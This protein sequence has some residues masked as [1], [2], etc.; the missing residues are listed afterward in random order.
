MN[1]MEQAKTEY[2]FPV[3]VIDSQNVCWPENLLIRRELQPGFDVALPVRVEGRGFILIDFGRELHGGARIVTYQVRNNHHSAPIRLRFGES[4]SEAC[5]PCG[6]KGASNVH[7]LREIETTLV[8]MSDMRFCQT[9]FRFLRIEFIEDTVLELRSIVAEYRHCGLKFSGSFRSSD[10]LV[11]HIYETAANT[12]YLNFQNGMIWDGIKR[13]RCV[14]VGDMHP[15]SLA[16]RALFGQSDYLERSLDFVVQTTP[17]GKWINDI[18]SYSM[19]WISVIRDYYF[20]TGDNVFLQ[21]FVDFLE[22][23][24]GMLDRSVTESG[25]L[26]FSLS[27]AKGEM[28]FFLDWPTYGTPDGYEGVFALLCRTA[29]AAGT[30]LSECGRPDPTVRRIKEKLAHARPGRAES[31]QVIAMRVLAGLQ[32]AELAAPRLAAGGEKGLSVFMSGYI[33][34]ALARCRGYEGKALDILRAYYGGMLKMGATTFWEDFDTGW[35]K[36]SCRIDELPQAGQKDIHGDFGRHCYAGFRHSLCHGWGASPVWFLTESIAGIEIL[37]PGCRRISLAPK[38]GGLEFVEC[39][40]PTPVGKL[41]MRAH[42]QGEET[43][44]EYD[45]PAGIKVESKQGGG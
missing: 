11:D 10:P 16:V 37:E 5:T 38:L 29:D 23:T 13:D 35:M 17:R 33:L 12:L 24:L 43:I 44:V 42:R 22:E 15:E 27:G 39:V 40:Y 14:W 6:V 21:K 36:D 41:W 2:V 9:G 7:S 25:K 4:L 20:H 32:S 18:P 34:S 26:D 19:H 8:S 1:F 31:K 45:A 28:P 30:I 3:R